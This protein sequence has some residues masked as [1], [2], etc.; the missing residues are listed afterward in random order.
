MWVYDDGALW[1]GID[2]IDE[3]TPGFEL[4]LKRDDMRLYKI[5]G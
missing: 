5:V 1:R 3:D 2:G 4:V